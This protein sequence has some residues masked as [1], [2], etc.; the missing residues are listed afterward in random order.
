MKTGS[1]GFIGARL[2]EAR[3][4]RGYTAVALADM[5][6]VT[7]S[8]VSHYER[9]EQSPRPEVMRKIEEVLD[10]P[11][12]FFWRV[13]ANDRIR[14]LFWRSLSAATKS[15]RVSAQIRYIWLEEIVR[16]LREYVNF[17]VVNFPDYE[18]P[19][20][21]ASISSELIEELAAK[22]RRFW[23]LGN[24]AISNVVW[25]L[26]NNGAVITRTKLEA[27]TLDAFSEWH[28]AEGVPYF[29]L[30][31]DKKVAARSRF[32][33]AH[34][35]GHIIL[36]R[37]VN[38]VCIGRHVDHKILEQQANRFAGAFLLPEQSFM[39]DVFSPSIDTFQSLKPK[40]GV[41]IQLMI[42]R[43]Q[44]L[45]LISTAQAERLWINC[46]RRGWRT[47]EPLDDQLPVEE[48]RLL[49]RSFELLVSEQVQSRAEI[50]SALP[51]SASEIEELAGLR[52]GFLA[53]RAL[54]VSLKGFKPKAKE[55]KEE[56]P[57]RRRD[58]VVV[59]FRP[60]TENDYADLDRK[61]M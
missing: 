38:G 32:D 23:K 44:D 42:H 17:P 33:V 19:K 29:I 50:L 1:P 57:P 59:A 9:G 53:E 60:R 10:L 31:A 14:N 35:L 40:W 18:M 58:D 61:R 36:H 39:G 34:E 49:R 27:D 25:L 26:E 51:Y 6:G 45:D 41:S 16:Y 52:E 8:G 48:P 37:Y 28:T 46:S 12:Q 4:A 22:T 11:P 20:K 56:L 55:K 13:P 21:P 3:Q 47:S 43:A 15:A 2:R 5:I 24:G 54:P 7:R 30:G